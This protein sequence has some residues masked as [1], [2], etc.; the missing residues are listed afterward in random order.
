[1]S[2][3]EGK[4]VSQLYWSK[5]PSLL[6]VSVNVPFVPTRVCRTSALVAM[7]AEAPAVQ[8]AVLA[9]GEQPKPSQ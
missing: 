8:V 4:V 2:Q 9:A 6:H 3:C 7:W 5:S 1:M